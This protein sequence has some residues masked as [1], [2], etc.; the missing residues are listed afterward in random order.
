MSRI[1]SLRLRV[2]ASILLVASGFMP[3]MAGPPEPDAYRMDEYRAPVPTTLKGAQV[4]TTADA[5]ALWRAK[6]A[7]FL[8]VMPRL[9]K[10]EKLPAGTIWRDKPRSN[11][12]G[13]IW[14]ANVG[15]GALSVDM[16][17][18]FRQSLAARTDGD[19]ARPILFYCMT[20]CWMSWNAAKR[21]IEWGYAKVLWYPEGADGWAKHGLPLADAKPYEMK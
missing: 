19:K 4:L 16:D 10:P 3:A 7:I 14:L 20:D 2:V 5:E 17:A 15:Y 13:S 11:I 6:G 9:P 21:A 12:P 8:D 1:V 18:Y